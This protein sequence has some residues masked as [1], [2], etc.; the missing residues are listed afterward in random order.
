LN[1]IKFRLILIPPIVAVI[2]LISSLATS[3]EQKQF[4]LKTS[5]S[6]SNAGTI[7]IADNT[8][9]PA[10]TKVDIT[11][12]PAE[13]YKFDHWE[14]DVAG[15]SPSA[16]AIMDKEKSAVACFIALKKNQFPLTAFIDPPGSGIVTPEKGIFDEG[17][18]A[19]VNARA[20]PGFQ[21][22]GWTGDIESKISSVSIIMDAKKNLTAHFK[23]QPKLSVS[24]DPPAAGS[25]S[26]S[27]GF[28]DFDTKVTITAF[29][30]SGYT[31]D[32]WSG[33]AEDNNNPQSVSMDKDRNL[34]AHF[35]PSSVDIF[36]GQNKGLI[37][38]V[39]YGS[40]YLNRMS[41]KVTSNCKSTI[42]VNIPAGIFFVSPNDRA[43]YSRMVNIES[44]I[45]FIKPGESK[46]IPLS[47]ASVDGAS[48]VPGKEDALLMD[49][50]S[51]PDDLQLLMKVKGLM[52]AT[53]RVRQYAVWVITLYPADVN[54]IRIG[55]S[56][57]NHQGPSQ[58]EF[59]Q[60][61]SLFQQAGIKLD[62]Y[63]LKAVDLQK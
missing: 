48:E 57:F 35:I 33:D 27:E 51:V 46:I 53:L 10:G 8:R 37:S 16:S 7:N 32:S 17:T 26:P 42:L 19:S 21:F 60:I 13:G 15:T 54:P 9:Y 58:D 34:T 38:A 36:D 25:A 14:G 49:I 18:K 52:G 20:L 23:P 11:A 39:G 24:V 45:E 44:S 1:K 4:G 59:D 62:K 61:R 47:S 43:H 12:N 50:K 40:G 56:N 31:F 41:V 3:C 22:D 5:I 6:P 2:I 29:P 55:T 28:F 63:P 30:L